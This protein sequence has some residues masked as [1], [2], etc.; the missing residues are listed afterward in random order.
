MFCAGLGLSI[1][2]VVT[3]PALVVLII[4]RYLSAI[5]IRKL[6][7]KKGL[8]LLTKSQKTPAHQEPHSKVTGEESVRESTGLGFCLYWGQG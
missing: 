1:T 2:S 4:A 3:R 8:L 6:E 7:G 5:T